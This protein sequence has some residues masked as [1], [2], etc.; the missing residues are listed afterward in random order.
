MTAAY[1]HTVT[2]DPPP[3]RGRYAGHNGLDV[4]RRTLAEGGARSPIS[5][6]M[7]F[8]LV[9]ADLGHVVF[10]GRPG[11]QH[12]NPIGIVHG[13]FA[14]TLLDAALWSAV[15]T[16]IEPGQGNTTVDLKVNYFRPMTAD[17]G[18][19]TCEA[20]IVNRGSRIAMAEGR[21]TDRAGKLYAHGASTLMILK[22]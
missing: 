5:A 6:L 8:D 9:R 22:L 16:T 10:E 21:I 3:E 7:D 15:Q 19:V 13:G 17:M 20:T 18:L 4:M 1:S 11:P 12:V 2:W 14:A